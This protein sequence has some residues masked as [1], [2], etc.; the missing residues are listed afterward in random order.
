[1][2]GIGMR[3]AT[4]VA[5]LGVVA[6]LAGCGGGSSTSNGSEASLTKAQF[7]KK[8]DQIC[9]R[10]YTRREQV[11]AGYLAKAEKEGQLPLAKQEEVL[12][13]QIMPIFREESEQL[14]ELGLPTSETQKAEEILKGLE[15]AIAAVESEP[16]V[17]LTKGTRVQ[18]AAVENLAHSYGFEFCGR[19]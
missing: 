5:L 18:F 11:L 17:A 3:G 7:V 6:V 12:V 16:D 15:A 19:S 14:N 4:V 1:M 10:N 2:Q 9:E 8:G 13:D